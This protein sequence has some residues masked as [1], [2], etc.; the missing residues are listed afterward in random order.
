M[1]EKRSKTKKVEHKLNFLKKYVDKPVSLYYN[2]A[3]K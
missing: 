1:R 2:I 3:G